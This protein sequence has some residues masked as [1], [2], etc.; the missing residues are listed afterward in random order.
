MVFNLIVNML[1]YTRMQALYRQYRPKAFSDVVGQPHI[2]NTL[3]NQLKRG[4]VAHAYLFVG[5]RGV[6][7]TS[8]ARLFAQAVNCL[9][10]ATKGE[11]CGECMNCVSIAQNQ[12]PDIIEIDAASH[13]GVDNV[14]TT[15]VEAI[16]F[17]PMQ[18]T[19]KV[20]IID[21]VHMLSTSAF[22][23]LLKTLEEPPAHALFILATT[24]FRKVPDTVASRC[25][26]YFFQNINESAIQETLAGIAQK[27]GRELTD[28][29][30]HAIARAAN[31]SLR[32]AE[33]TLEQVFGTTNGRIAIDH[34]Q[35]IVPV[36]SADIVVK[37]L[38][39]SLQK[40]VDTIESVLAESTS[41]GVA[42]RL[43]LEELI[44]LSRALLLASLGG[45]K[46][47]SLWKNHAQWDE[48][49]SLASAPMLVQTLRALTE[50]STR[51]IDIGVPYLGIQ[52]ALISVGIQTP[53]TQA[54]A[55]QVVNQTP[56]SRPPVAPS[57]PVV[58][59]APAASQAS[60]PTASPAPAPVSQAVPA[61][62]ATP[63]PSYT[64]AP[65][66]AAEPPKPLLN[67]DYQYTLE[68]LQ[69]K[70]GRCCEAVTRQSV[71][72]PLVLKT[73][74][75][76]NYDGTVMEVTFDR[77]FHYETMSEVRNL[78]ILTSAV[79]EVIQKEIIIKPVFVPRVEEKQIDDVVSAFG[80]QVMDEALGA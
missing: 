19:R 22:N 63:T 78:N 26:R 58:H 9:N 2:V 80:G 31:G 45:Q 66:T 29:S 55:V 8:V 72:L 47:Q 52:L 12:F 25:Q 54:P 39:A 18:G 48:L 41:G 65:Q 59:H 20:F 44:D 1:A 3:Q 13:T 57:A 69:N 40:D 42:M 10:I 76:T 32:D 74:K 62:E 27:E 71:S 70:W 16:R 23:A 34:V 15:I 43:L 24:E 30:L 53:I 50:Y 36:P 17:A 73:A 37:L 49:I 5:T 7:K 35:Q 60:V 4:S 21:E 61:S 28:E 38:K 51:S 33:R 14:R 6:G 46:V 75:P 56:T 11:M 77:A 79:R 64:P 68:E 67:A